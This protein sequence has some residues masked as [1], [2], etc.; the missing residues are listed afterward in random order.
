MNRISYLLFFLTLSM[1]S[2]CSEEVE[3]FP[4]KPEPGSSI[5]IIGNSFAEGLQRNNYF[6]TLMHESFSDHELYV[7]NLAWNA[8]EVNLRPRPLN[9]GTLHDHI[10]GHQADVIIACF[11][12]NESFKGPDSLNTFINDLETFL[13]SLK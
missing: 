10:E 3:V 9:F 6:E 4:F 5:V 7:R 2:S 12:M 1:L 13:L 8:D 11:G